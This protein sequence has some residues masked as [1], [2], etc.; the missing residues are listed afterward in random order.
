MSQT[1]IGFGAV[2]VPDLGVR[3][4]RNDQPGRSSRILAGS[5]V[6]VDGGF[7]SSMKPRPL[8]RAGQPN[9]VNA[10]ALIETSL[11][12]KALLRQVEAN[13][14]RRRTAGRQSLGA[15]DPR[16][17]HFGL[18][19]A[20]FCD[21][22]GEASRA[23]PERALRPLVLPHPWIEKRPFVLAA[24]SRCGRQPGGIPLP[25][26]QGP[27]ALEGAFHMEPGRTR[28]VRAL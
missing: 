21:W 18:P 10:V 13:R 23:L 2:I 7:A 6:E 11:P 9:Y 20:G 1:L 26:N 24:A 17:R 14:T 12:P 3:L 5:G 19:R 28:I 15:A 8:G 27:K 4:P 22:R 25:R 16:Y